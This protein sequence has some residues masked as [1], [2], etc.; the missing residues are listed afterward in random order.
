MKECT[1]MIFTIMLDLMR[2]EYN[3][4]L[5][6]FTPCT[7]Q[8]HVP[9]PNYHRHSHS[10]M[11]RFLHFPLKIAHASG[12][13]LIL[14]KQIKNLTLYPGLLATN[15]VDEQLRSSFV[16]RYRL[17]HLPNNLYDSHGPQ[18]TRLNFQ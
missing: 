13:P 17:S 9:N 2:S 11:N 7:L 16:R 10:T 12:F 4:S 3:P 1:R 15:T 6:N 8:E 14:K 5:Y 18:F